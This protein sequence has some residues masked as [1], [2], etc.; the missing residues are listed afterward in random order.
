MVTEISPGL[1]NMSAVPPPEQYRDS[2]NLARR[3]NLHSKY[4]SSGGPWPI[5]RELPVAPGA[6]VLEV[7]CGTGQFWVE[8]AK[9]WPAGLDITLTDLSPG[10][11]D[12]ALATVRAT[13]RWGQV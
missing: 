13:G 3:M 8:T 4:G 11:V 7:G 2:A 5:I 9:V 1:Q 6:R 12:E 10:M